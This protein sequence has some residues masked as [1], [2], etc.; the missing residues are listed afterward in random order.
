[1]KIGYIASHIYLHT[2]EINEASEL[3]RQHPGARVY[4]FYRP[5]GSQ[6]QRQRVAE[7]D[8][9]IVSWTFRSILKSLGVVR[10]HPIGF[11]KAAAALSYHSLANP[12]YWVK[13]FVTFLIALPVLDDAERHGV[14]H[15]HANFG[16]S[17]ATVAWLGRRALGTGMS[18][19]YH[20]FD[21][22]SNAYASRDP[23]KRQKLLDADL[24]VSVHEDGRQ[25]LQ[26]IAPEAAGDKFRV[27]R[28]CVAF[29]PETKTEPL[30][31]PPLLLAAGNL[32]PKKGF[33]ILVRAVG[34]LKRRGVPVRL[35]ILGEGKQRPVL[36]R[37]IREQGVRDRV[38]L[39]GYFQH[40]ELAEHLAQAAAFVVP[41][42]ITRGGQRDGI[43]TVGV[44]AWLSRT[45]VIA[46]LVGGMGEVIR[47]DETGLVFPP[48]DSDALAEAVIRL[49]NSPEL[50]DTI[51]AGGYRT[52]QEFFSS[53]KN[54]S[55]LLGEIKSCP[56]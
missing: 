49:L 8:G 18:V 52:A 30:P 11:L 39:R 32:V 51:V 27:I 16:S 48:G 33:N 47:S 6:L 22:Y 41:S 38:E 46:S 50:Q 19:T 54:V 25:L 43:P 3:V 1:M 12:V 23:L 14:T 10:R 7:V 26:R 53:S 35:R 13:N 24:V 28:I 9:D 2:F 34:A 40:R 44:E 17:P 56:S 55:S 37:L 31:E 45:P 21:I 5:R 42:L 29:D 4:S 15:L 20:A 36:E